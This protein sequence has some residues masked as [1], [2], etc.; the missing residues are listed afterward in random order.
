[1]EE[2]IFNASAIALPPSDPSPFTLFFGKFWCL[3]KKN[4]KTKRFSKKIHYFQDSSVEWKS[5]PSMLLQLLWFHLVLCN[6]LLFF[7]VSFG[8]WGKK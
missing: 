5:W 8:V 4:E 7:L 1:M 6:C 3:R 2:L